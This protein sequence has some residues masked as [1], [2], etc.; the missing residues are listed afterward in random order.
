MD[1][2]V[3][4]FFEKNM[5]KKTVLAQNFG[6]IKVN[7]GRF[8]LGQNF[9]QIIGRFFLEKNFAQCLKISPKWRNFAQS[10]HP[11]GPPGVPR[12]RKSLGKVRTL[13]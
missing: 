7:F 13:R 5:F 8:F 10:G 4:D 2:Q 6:L 1:R 12:C 11:D 3:M 9:A